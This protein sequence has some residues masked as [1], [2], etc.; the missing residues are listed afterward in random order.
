MTLV[1]SE[2]NFVG[3]LAFHFL[4]SLD[5]PPPPHTHTK[6]TPGSAL[7]L[8]LVGLRGEQPGIK[9]VQ[10]TS[11]TKCFKLCTVSM[12][13]RISMNLI[14]ISMNLSSPVTPRVLPRMEDQAKKALK[15]WPIPS[16]HSHSPF[17][18]IEAQERP[19]D[20]S[21]QTQNQGQKVIHECLKE[22]NWDRGD[23]SMC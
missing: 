15:C 22:L 12:N 20:L 3:V 23:E 10:V 21:S 14:R 9:L 19:V 5:L 17:L 1:A 13:L 2:T 4:F 6:F 7:R 11:K 18:L 8:F 16:K